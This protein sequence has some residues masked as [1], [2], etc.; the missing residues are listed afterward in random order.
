MLIDQVRRQLK[1]ETGLTATTGAGQRN[2][3]MQR[4]EFAQLRHLGVASD[5]SRQLSAQ[6]VRKGIEGAQGRK[7]HANVGVAQLPHPLRPAQILQ[8]V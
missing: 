3:S 5:K 7:F 8:P 1:G 2:Q 4:Q 6:V